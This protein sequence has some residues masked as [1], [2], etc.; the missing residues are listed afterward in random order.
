MKEIHKAIEQELNVRLK[1]KTVKITILS[2]PIQC[3]KELAFHGFIG[4]TKTKKKTVVSFF[5]PLSDVNLNALGI[6]KLKRFV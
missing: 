5:I 2:M 4:S 6:A 1:N 3:G